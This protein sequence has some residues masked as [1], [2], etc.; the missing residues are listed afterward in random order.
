MKVAG[1]QRATSLKPDWAKPR[2][3]RRSY[4]ACSLAP[5]Q[6]DA[7]PINSLRIY[8]N[9]LPI[10]QLCGSCETSQQELQS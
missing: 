10:F 6:Q 9:R 4:G 2:D 8:R 7:N 1:P 5:V 3:A